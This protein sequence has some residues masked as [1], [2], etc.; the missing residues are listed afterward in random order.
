MQNKQVISDKEI[1]KKNEETTGRSALLLL[2]DVA[3]A[4]V[5][6]IVILQFVKPTI[7]FEHSMQDTLQPRDYV[8]LAKQAYRTHAPER[9][10]IVVFRSN[11]PN[12]TGG[13]TKDLIKRVIGLPGE[14]VEVRDGSVYIN[15]KP[16]MEDYTKDGTTDGAMAPM[17][18]PAGEYFMMGDNR[19]VSDDSRDP[20]VGCIPEKDILGRVFFRL[21]PIS[22]A[23]GIYGNLNAYNLDSTVNNGV[24]STTNGTVNSAGIAGD[25]GGATSAAS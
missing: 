14:T 7:V 25:T 19:Q 6:I 17:K 16:L 4:L 20:Q 23:G 12:D 15:G 5:I 24:N 3:I 21:F 22:R 18:I 8:L 11:L 2:R 1:L 13:G 10:D 9:G